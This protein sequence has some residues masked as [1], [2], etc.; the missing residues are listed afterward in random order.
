[1]KLSEIKGERTFDVIADII[2][3]IA[4]IAEDK[5]CMKL[6]KKQKPPK[7]V[8]ARA[9]AIKRLKKGVP[10]LLRDHKGDIMAIMAAIEG[11][12]VEEYAASLNLA[13]LTTDVIELATD[14]AFVDLFISAQKEEAGGTS[15]AAPETITEPGE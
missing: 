14:E 12:S 6:F 15:T 10:A 11:V 1:M 9:Y 7:G 3:P 2:D 4:N 13:K 5:E 8:D